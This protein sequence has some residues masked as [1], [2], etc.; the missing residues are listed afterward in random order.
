MVKSWNGPGEP[1]VS[2]GTSENRMILGGR[3]LEQKFQSTMMDMPFEGYGLTGYDNGAKQYWFFWIDNLSTSMMAGRGGMDESG[4][5]LTTTATMPGP[6]G[7][8]M[9]VRIVTAI[10]DE[11][12]H[13]FSMY[14]QMG[15]KEMLMMEITYTRL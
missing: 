15:G 14:G 6:D 4:K 8:P 9:D 12:Q 5:T 3:Y 2:E 11:N 13:V 7:K 10:V 1:A